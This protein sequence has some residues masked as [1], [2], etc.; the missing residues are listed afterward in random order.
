MYIYRDNLRVGRIILK[1]FFR[2]A[3][4]FNKSRTDPGIKKSL[5]IIN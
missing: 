2:K 4:I 1:K 3:L 5:K